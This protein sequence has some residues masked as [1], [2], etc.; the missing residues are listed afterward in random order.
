MLLPRRNAGS[1]TAADHLIV[2]D[3]ALTQL[4][5][6]WRSKKVLIRADGAGYS[7]ALIATPSNQGLDSSVGY[8]VIEAVGVPKH[9]WQPKNNSDG[10]LPEHANVIEVTGLLDLSR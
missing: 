9:A 8:P 10:G 5:D 4:P 3:L 2:L 1:N 7:H 6:R